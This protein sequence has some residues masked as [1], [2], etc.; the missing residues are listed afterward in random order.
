MQEDAG[1]NGGGGE[2][3]EEGRGRTEDG[4]RRR[5]DGRGRREE[6]VRRSHLGASEALLEPSWA[7]LA[8]L[9]APP[10]PTSRS[11]GDGRRRG[12]PLPEGEHNVLGEEG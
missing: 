8:A 3:G 4:G 9:T 5:D 12:K 1:G 10:P 11:R 2:R 6:R 7:F